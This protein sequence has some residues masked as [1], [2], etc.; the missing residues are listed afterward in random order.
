MGFKYSLWN[1]FIKGIILIASLSF[2]ASPL[3]V[4]KYPDIFVIVIICSLVFFIIFSILFV[5]E[6]SYS[7]GKGNSLNT[8]IERSYK[9]S[10]N[11]ESIVN[12]KYNKKRN[13]PNDLSHKYTKKLLKDKEKSLSRNLKLKL[14][15]SYLKLT[16]KWEE[17]I[18]AIL[19]LINE[20]KVFDSKE[21]RSLINLRKNIM[22]VYESEKETLED[23][24]E[25]YLNRISS[26]EDQSVYKIQMENIIKKVRIKLVNV[27]I[28]AFGLKRMT[29]KVFENLNKKLFLSE[30]WDKMEKKKLPFQKIEEN[31]VEIKNNK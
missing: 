12:K 14:Q 8:S 20:N 15:L 21:N 4:Y 11:I 6:R 18:K 2:L 7:E 22:Q 10:E 28:K 13:S 31:E 17:A 23:L 29:K 27:Y 5:I 19:E 9:R 25:D 3:L 26:I 16:S 24:E 30:K 1:N